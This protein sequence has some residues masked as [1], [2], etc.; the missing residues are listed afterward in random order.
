[1]ANLSKRPEGLTGRITIY[2]TYEEEE[3]LRALAVAEGRKLSTQAM[4][5]IAQ[6]PDMKGVPDGSA[7]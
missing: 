4:R 6:H 1:M 2:P 3:Q 7:A 5:M